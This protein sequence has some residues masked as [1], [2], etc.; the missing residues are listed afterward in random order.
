MIIRKGFDRFFSSKNHTEMDMD[1]ENEFC[2]AAKKIKIAQIREMSVLEIIEYIVKLTEDKPVSLD[3]APTKFIK[4]LSERLDITPVQALM[5]SVFVNKCDDN[6]IVLRDLA[7]HFDGNNISILKC[8][9]DIEA[10]AKLGV[11]KRQ[12]ERRGNSSYSVPQ[13]TLD[14]LCK[15]QLPEPPKST[16]LNAYEW[17]DAVDDLMQDVRYGNI[18][19]DEFCKQIT[20]LIDNNLHLNCTQTIK[21]HGLDTDDLK[22]FMAI[23]LCAINNNDDNICMH[24]IDDYYKRPELRMIV[25]ELEDGEHILFAENLI[26]HVNNHGM[27]DTSHWKLTDYSKNEVYRE[28]RFRKPKMGNS[29]LIMPDKIVEK[30]L[31]YNDEINKQINDLHQLLENDRMKAIL[32]RLESK[33]MRRGFACLFYGTPGTGKTETVLQLAKATGR[34]IMQVNISSIRSKW[35][36]ETEQNIK[37]CFDTY[38]KFAINSDIAPILFFNEADALFMTRID[39]AENSVD[40]MENAMQNIILQEMENLEGILIATTNLQTSLDSA[41]ERRFLYKIEFTK[42]T[43]AERS[44]I[45]QAMLPEL[46]HSD[47]LL[48]AER[49]DFSGGQIEN[50][51]RKCLIN[52]ILSERDALDM[53]TLIESCKH[54]SLKKE[55]V[56]RVGFVD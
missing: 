8:N 53:E 5:M 35:V 12:G 41:F 11:I 22:L 39:T 7:S 1:K 47:A 2:K 24:D 36:G 43:P 42:P 28:F 13:K 3:G 46:S 34:P 38:R 27:V 16:G 45:W 26:E 10:L 21:N 33:G 49:F 50:I 14:A 18:N 9:D 51:T 32:D 40:K 6:S 52:D 30:K 31:Y 17:L 55:K 54:E 37:A 4:V 25:N 15:D 29:E 20:S 19:D 48:L 23:S 44:H 56:K